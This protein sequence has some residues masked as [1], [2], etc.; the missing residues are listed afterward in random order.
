M[1]FFR[2]FEGQTDEWHK[3][4]ILPLPQPSVRAQ[5]EKEMER[6]FLVLLRRYHI[7]IL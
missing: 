6:K 3:Q 2:N 5:A 4:I 7:H 1:V